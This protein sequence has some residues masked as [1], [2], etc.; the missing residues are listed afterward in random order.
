M[1]NPPKERIFKV[2][3]MTC[4]HC[5]KAVEAAIGQLD[6]VQSVRVDL[7]AGEAKVVGNANDQAVT[8]AVEDAGYKATSASP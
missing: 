1:S 5:Q 4:G 7:K 2:T 3:G 8:A 6:G